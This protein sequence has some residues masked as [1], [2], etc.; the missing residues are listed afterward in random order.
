MSE[1]RQPPSGLVVIAHDVTGKI[2]TSITP[3]RDL[4]RSN[5]HGKE[6]AVA[7]A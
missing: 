2:V 3:N 4:I 6:R 7:Q 1:H 5:A